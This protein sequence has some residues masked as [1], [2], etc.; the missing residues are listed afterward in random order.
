MQIQDG[1]TA[2]LVGYQ[3]DNGHHGAVAELPDGG[4]VEHARSST[5]Q[6]VDETAEVD[7][8]TEVKAKVVAAPKSD[9]PAKAEGAQTA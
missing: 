7:V 3:M 4:V 2:K 6:L 1:V 8:E 5:E 9:A